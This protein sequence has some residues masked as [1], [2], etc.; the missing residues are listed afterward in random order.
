MVHKV[1]VGDGEGRGRKAAVQVGGG[2]G[3]ARGHGVGMF[4]FGGAYWPLATAHSDPLWARTCF[5]CVN[6]STGWGGGVGVLRIQS[7]RAG[8]RQGTSV[9]E[10]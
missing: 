8:L 3:L 6:V 10:P 5:G 9:L 2:G 1:Y 4:A 7:S